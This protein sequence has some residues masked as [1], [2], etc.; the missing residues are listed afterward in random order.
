VSALLLIRHKQRML[1]LGRIREPGHAGPTPESWALI[2]LEV[3]REATT[4]VAC[5]CVCVL[6]VYKCCGV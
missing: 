4:R 5:V 3:I 2:G 1:L 6:H